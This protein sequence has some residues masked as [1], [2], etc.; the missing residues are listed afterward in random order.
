VD[1][2]WRCDCLGVNVVDVEAD[3]CSVLPRTHDNEPPSAP[4]VEQVG[5][6][7]A[8][9]RF[10]FSKPAPVRSVPSKRYASGGGTEDLAMEPA[11]H[12]RPRV[13]AQL[14]GLQPALN[15]SIQATGGRGADQAPGQLHEREGDLAPNTS[16][17]TTL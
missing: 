6:K 12:G 9:S 7:R 15:R 16:P 8:C 13:I 5:L 17:S 14:R 3:Q 1:R 4:A 10:A 2:R 11:F